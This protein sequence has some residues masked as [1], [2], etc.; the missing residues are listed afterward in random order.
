M[1]RQVDTNSLDKATQQKLRRHL[2]SSLPLPLAQI[3][4]IN[5][6]DLGIRGTELFNA[7]TRANREAPDHCPGSIFA[8]LRAFAFSLLDATYRVDVKRGAQNNDSKIRVI[9]VSLKSARTCIEHGEFDV[10]G[11]IFQ[12]VADHVASLADSD[13]GKD[14]DNDDSVRGVT[15][16][17]VSDFWILR[18]THSWKTNRIDLAEHFLKSV[19]LDADSDEGV[20]LSL[21]HI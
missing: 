16:L 12:A 11:Q 4:S 6:T 21:I 18:A 1:K 15:R 17:M 8:L 13:H 20:A 14:S 19:R 9:T 10:C 2:A 5:A 7:A 3:R